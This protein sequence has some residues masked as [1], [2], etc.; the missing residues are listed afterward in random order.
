MNVRSWIL[1]Y[2]EL[3]AD[4]VDAL[5]SEGRI[6]G[7]GRVRAPARPVQRDLVLVDPT[8]LDRPAG[9]TC[10]AHP[11]GLAAQRYT[12]AWDVSDTPSTPTSADIR[13]TVEDA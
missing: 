4:V 11:V 10:P 1:R 2:E 5:L 3:A 13:T 9:V 12:R 8:V 6:D 7:G